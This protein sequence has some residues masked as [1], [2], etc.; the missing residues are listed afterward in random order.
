MKHMQ[1]Q[2]SRRLLQ[3]Q[4]LQ[5]LHPGSILVMFEELLSVVGW[6]VHNFCVIDLAFSSDSA[7]AGSRVLGG[8]RGFTKDVCTQP[9][10]SDST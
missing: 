7:G 5:M 10:T 8:S 1:I 2:R 9:Y 4:H 6:R 3:H